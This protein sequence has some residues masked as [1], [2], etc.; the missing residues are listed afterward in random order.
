MT[1]AHQCSLLSHVAAQVGQI[2]FDTSR[3]GCSEAA[4][5]A[6][7]GTQCCWQQL[8]QLATWVVVTEAWFSCSL[9]AKPPKALTKCLPPGT[10]RIH[11]YLLVQTSH[12]V[13][14]GKEVG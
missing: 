14:E 12:L 1:K 3:Q 8:Q 6:N 13:G 5:D 9:A 11:K 2:L 7:C 10:I 4:E